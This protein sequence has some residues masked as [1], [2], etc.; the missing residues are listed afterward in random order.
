MHPPRPTL[1]LSAGAP[2]WAGGWSRGLAR[3]FSPR[4]EARLPHPPC[5]EETGC[6]PA[7]TAP[8]ASAAGRGHCKL[9]TRRRGPAARERWRRWRWRGDSRR[10]RAGWAGREGAVGRAAPVRPPRA[11]PPRHG[12]ARRLRTAGAP[13][14]AGGGVSKGPLFDGISVYRVYSLISTCFLLLLPRLLGTP[15]R[16]GGAP[17]RSPAAGC[18]GGRGLGLPRPPP[19]AAG[20]RMSRRP[21]HR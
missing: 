18:G 6:P 15:V 8:S 12:P 5:T 11:P 3:E 16:G 20:A 4:G 14:L 9:R 2:A 19:Q 1:P 17:R 21:R 13:D 7:P 10:C